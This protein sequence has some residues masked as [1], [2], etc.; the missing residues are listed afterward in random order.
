MCRSRYPTKTRPVTAMSSLSAIVVLRAVVPRGESV[1][2]GMERK[3][4]R[5]DPQPALRQA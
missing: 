1:V 5:A 3:V 4:P 2:V